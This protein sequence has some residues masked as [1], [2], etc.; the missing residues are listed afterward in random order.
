MTISWEVDDGY[1]GGRRPQD[2]EVGDAEIQERD[3]VEEAMA[4]IEECVRD[5]FLEKISWRFLDKGIEGKVAKL[6]K[7][8][9]TEDDE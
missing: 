5:D 7:D 8:K 3:S 6:L 4:Y 1:C 9:P 2:S